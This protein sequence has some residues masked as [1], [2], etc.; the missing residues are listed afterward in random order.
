MRETDRQTD[1]QTEKKRDRQRQR[2]TE[3][4][5]VRERERQRDRDREGERE[6]ERERGRGRDKFLIFS[7]NSSRNEFHTPFL[8]YFDTQHSICKI[9]IFPHFV[10]RGSQGVPKHS[11]KTM[12]S[13][14]NFFLL[15]QKNL[16]YFCTGCPKIA[17]RVG[18][19]KLLE[20]FFHRGI[21]NKK[22]GKIIFRYGLP[23]VF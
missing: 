21:R 15:K 22:L 7:I 16:K 10:C 1:R 9:F 8:H 23:E 11:K 5:T 14:N 2:E 17:L 4:E 3:R 18:K 19:I 13:K 12:I 6:R 20:F